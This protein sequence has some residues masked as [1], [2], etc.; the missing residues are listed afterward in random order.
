MHEQHGTSWKRKGKFA[1]L[2]VRP[3]TSEN[4]SVAHVC[5]MKLWKES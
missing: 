1:N 4:A 3:P 2:Y 5:E